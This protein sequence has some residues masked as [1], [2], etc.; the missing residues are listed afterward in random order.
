MFF[1]KKEDRPGRAPPQ[2]APHSA[3]R[4]SLRRL[5][6]LNPLGNFR[7]FRSWRVLG[8]ILTLSW[9]ILAFKTPPR[10][11]KTPSRPSKM[12]PRSSKTSKTPPAGGP[13]TLFFLMFFNVFALQSYLD[14][15]RPPRR[16]Q[17]PPGR[18][19]DAFKSLQDPSKSFQDGPTSLQDAPKSLQDAPKTFQDGSKTP[20]RER[21]KSKK[22]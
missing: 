8:P 18:L 15:T 12:P 20:L 22:S 21:P 7:G 19:Q 17:E 2:A 5:G 10:A 6:G 4:S 3:R 1:L 9:L 14:P 16:L 13:K 11:S